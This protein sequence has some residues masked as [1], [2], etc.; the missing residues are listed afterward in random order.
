MKAV[1]WLRLPLRFTGTGRISR[2]RG[3]LLAVLLLVLVGILSLRSQEGLLSLAAS[4]AALT[5]LLVGQMLLLPVVAI[6]FVVRSGWF[7]RWESRC[8]R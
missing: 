4:N 5:L 2:R 3:A 7:R 8:W 6:V 1:S